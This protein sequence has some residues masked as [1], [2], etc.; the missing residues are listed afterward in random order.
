MLPKKLSDG[1]YRP[2]TRNAQKWIERFWP[3]IVLTPDVG[4]HF[5]KH[6]VNFLSSW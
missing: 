6:L 3:K 1:E 5:D 2:E 4:I